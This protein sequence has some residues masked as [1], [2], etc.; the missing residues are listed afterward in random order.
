MTRTEAALV[1]DAALASY[2]VPCA[3]G[4]VDAVLAPAV[5]LMPA[6]PFRDPN[7]ACWSHTVDAQ[8]YAGRMDDVGVYDTL[9]L[10]ADTFIRTTRA[11][12]IINRGAVGAP[13][14]VTVGNVDY[15][16]V[17]FTLTLYDLGPGLAG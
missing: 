8:L 10:L 9:D 5:V 11:N 14:T 2:G 3:P 13:E 17:T 1:L 16:T 15:L 12:G 4:P 7:P 6:A